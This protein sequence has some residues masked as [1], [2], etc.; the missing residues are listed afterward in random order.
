MPGKT[1]YPWSLPALKALGCV[2][3]LN[4]TAGFLEGLLCL[5]RFLMDPIISWIALT[6][7]GDS[8]IGRVGG[9]FSWS[10]A[11]SC[12]HPPWSCTCCEFLR[13]KK[14]GKKG[15]LQCTA[16]TIKPVKS[17]YRGRAERTPQIPVEGLQLPLRLWQHPPLELSGLW[18]ASQGGKSRISIC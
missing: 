18:M 10:L 6:S 4:L 8:R 7:V 13:G 14:G 11:Y 2:A 17:K 3:L 1:W 12:K 15:L 5:Q 16:S 9:F